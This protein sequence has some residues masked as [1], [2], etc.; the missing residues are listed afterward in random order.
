MTRINTNVQS[1]IARRALA[2]N[3]TSLNEDLCR[4]STGLH[5]NFVKEDPTGL[6]TS[7]TLR[8]SLRTINTAI[9]QVASLRGRLEGFQKDTLDTTI[10]SLRVASENISAAESAIRDADFAVETS[11][12]TRAQ[13]LVEKVN[14][15]DYHAQ[16]APTPTTSSNDPRPSL[17]V[18]G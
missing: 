1:L 15:D 12:L 3:N 5:I 7:E 4:L 18:E 2:L 17:S 9:D 13:I 10:N 8:S 14:K 16:A 11:N 6:I